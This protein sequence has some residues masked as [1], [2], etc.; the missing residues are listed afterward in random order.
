MVLKLIFYNQLDV[1]LE[2]LLKMQTRRIEHWG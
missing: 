2:E 1:I